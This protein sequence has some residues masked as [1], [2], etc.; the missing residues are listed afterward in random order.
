[1]VNKK[2]ASKLSNIPQVVGIIDSTSSLKAAL[3]INAGELDFFEIRVDAFAG[4]KGGEDEILA[5]LPKLKL[6]LIITVRHALEG[7]LHAI[8][9]RKRREYFER[10]LP[11]AKLIDVELRSAKSLPGILA[12]AR[13]K[14]VS[15]ILS[16]HNFLTTPPASRLRALENA[17]RKAGADIFKVATVAS[18]P[19]DIAALLS[20]AHA[21]RKTPVSLMGMGA[22][23]KVSRLVFAQAGSVLNY[24]FLDKAQVSG[25]WP[26]VLL[27]ERI[28]ELLGA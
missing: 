11:H 2:P 24:G 22:F 6:P 5:A 9:T 16:Y 28:A 4:R 21:K 13:S 14:K 1:M 12:L 19:A 10:F 27:K 3:R 26:A 23:G 17:A 25:Q 20:L 7:G 18:T 15:I 8:S